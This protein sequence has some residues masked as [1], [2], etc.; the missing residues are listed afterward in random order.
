[1]L[2]RKDPK[3]SLAGDPAAA[4]DPETQA[5]M[6]AESRRSLRFLNDHYQ[7]FLKQYPD[8]W[9]AVYLEELVAVEPTH[10]EL[11]EQVAALGIP[12]SNMYARFM[13][14]DRRPRA[15]TPHFLKGQNRP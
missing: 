13:N 1:M 8:Q 10:R 14:T 2:N 12:R 11:L 6:W 9:V 3:V 7:E 15:W 5:R 4:T